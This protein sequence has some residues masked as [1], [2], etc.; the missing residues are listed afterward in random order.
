MDFAGDSAFHL[1]VDLPEGRLLKKDVLTHLDLLY[2]FMYNT[3]LWK[4]QST[5]SI[6]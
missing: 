3:T 1:G 4:T 2:G 6:P 5:A